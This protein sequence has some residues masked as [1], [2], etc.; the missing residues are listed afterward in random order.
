VTVTPVPSR[1]AEA[2]DENASVEQRFL[3]ATPM[4]RPTALLPE[5]RRSIANG[6][7]ARTGARQGRMRRFALW[8]GRRTWR[9]RR[10]VRGWPRS[11]PD[12]RR[13]TD[14]LGAL[15]RRARPAA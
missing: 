8:V 13:R 11:K 14:A 3:A 15:P 1:S 4:A 9:G 10:V 2:A 7:V 6:R 5:R 12:G